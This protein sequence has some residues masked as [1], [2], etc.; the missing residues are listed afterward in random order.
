MLQHLHDL[1]HCHEACLYGG[2][3]HLKSAYDKSDVNQQNRNQQ[4]W[5]LQPLP[6]SH[7]LLC[8]SEITRWKATQSRR[9]LPL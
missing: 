6:S 9:F 3:A 7:T 5:I 4:N 2:T 8:V 1:S